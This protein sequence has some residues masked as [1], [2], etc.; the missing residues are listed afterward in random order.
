[1]KE[2]AETVKQLLKEA[3]KAQ[4]AASS[5]IQQAAADIKSTNNLLSSVSTRID[6]IYVTSSTSTRQLSSYSS[7]RTW[8]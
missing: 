3:Q 2:S 5:A 1:M 4:T 7:W 6:S 8:F